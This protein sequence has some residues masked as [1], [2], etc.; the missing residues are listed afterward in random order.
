[1]RNELTPLSFEEWRK[2]EK[3]FTECFLPPM[4]NPA[5]DLPLVPMRPY[6]SP[7]ARALASERKDRRDESDRALGAAIVRMGTAL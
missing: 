6:V 4:F 2:L 5:A 3:F 1:M 7:L